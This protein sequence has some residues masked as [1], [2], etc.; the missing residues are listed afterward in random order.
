MKYSPEQEAY[1][2]ELRTGSSHIVLRACAG[3]G[4]TTTVIE[5]LPFMRGRISFNAFNKKMAEELSNRIKRK[6]GAASLRANA[7]TLHSVGFG[8]LKN[9]LAASGARDLKLKPD[10]EKLMDLV[11][12]VR[13]KGAHQLCKLVDLAKQHG[14]GIPGI[15]SPG[16]EDLMDHFNIAPV[17]K[18]SHFI[19][20]AEQL[21][22]ASISVGR[23][24]IDFSDMIYL[25]LLWDFP[26]ETYH[27][28]VLDETQDISAIR[29]EI[30]IKMLKPEGR[31][32]A[33][34]DDQQAI[35]GFTGADSQAINR[36]VQRMN[37]KEMTLSVSW[38]CP[39]SVIASIQHISPLIQPRPD[40][41]EGL[42]QWVPPEEVDALV[43]P[44]DAILC[45]LNAPLLRQ[46]LSFIRKGRKA[47]IEGRD[48]G[49][50]LMTLARRRKWYDL[51]ELEAN[52]D[53]I[54]DFERDKMQQANT[55]RAVSKYERIKDSLDTL[56][57]IAG[58]AHEIGASSQRDFENLIDSL[59]GDEV[60]AADTITLSSVHKAKGLEW[61]RVFI[62]GRNIY[63][64][65]RAAELPW[66]QEQEQNLIYVAHTRA[67]SELYL[68]GY[69][70]ESN[71]E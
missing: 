62:L 43:Q 67:Q 31:L 40:A 63:M 19:E 1:F 44:G 56:R 46:C 26:F 36:I 61:P 32:I 21:L 10:S 11:G 59:F 17:G 49:K 30:A 28:V 70:Q 48:I 69:P 52:L 35:F 50:S 41:P 65:F 22:R 42:V 8:A 27:E 54:E 33:V 64:P 12:G 4:K 66:E 16:W 20:Q 60:S 39:R 57:V 7:A 14:L 6:G 53:A 55:R 9:G 3:A 71:H 38:R 18:E 5:G 34:G 15:A 58:R 25:P 23:E 13:V 68:V 24:R 2:E 51:E 45:R 37:A 47:R 29:L